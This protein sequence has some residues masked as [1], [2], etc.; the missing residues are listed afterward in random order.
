MA[1]FSKVVLENQVLHST[2]LA[3]N[4]QMPI[5]KRHG[6]SL[7][8][9]LDELP[10]GAEVLEDGSVLFNFYAPAAET[11]E[12]WCADRNIR[13]EKHENKIWTGKMPFSTPGHK[14][15]R[16]IVDGVE[17]INPLAPI[18][19]GASQPMN[20]ID[21]PEVDCDFYYLKDVE[22]GTVCSEV[23]KSTVTG[24]FES[25]IV[26]TPPGY[27]QGSEKYPILY[28]QHGHGENEKCWLYQ[29]KI[30]YIM[31]N[32]IA[33]GK[34]APCLIVMN[35]GMVQTKD[36][37]GDRIVNPMLFE[38]V[39][40]QDII[41]FIEKR[42][43]VKEG[44]E[45]RAMAGLSMGSMQTSIIALKHPDLFTWVGIFSGFLRNIFTEDNS[46]LKA[47]EDPH[48]LSKEF[49]LFFRAMGTEDPFIK[50]FYEDDKVCQDKGFV[51]DKYSCIIRKMYKGSH[52]WQVWRKCA[53]DFLQLTFKQ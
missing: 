16:F 53:Y 19:F 31:D 13:L 5:S 3:Y 51:S 44:K 17:V 4:K 23:F 9:V 38:Q 46:H 42:Y 40:L 24:Q 34:A 33:E 12:V 26:Y 14:P 48:Y 39:L 22:H 27:M 25:C 52:E 2:A 10:L 50:E 15:L 43:R 49:K 37:T 30:N 28:L 32:L 7:N 8:S 18:G 41:P 6:T 21:I 47:L 35:N 36:E 20:C 1:I 29:G 11:V 45:N